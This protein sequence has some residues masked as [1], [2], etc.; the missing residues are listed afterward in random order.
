MFELQ[1]AR[2]LLHCYILDMEGILG[3]FGIAVLVMEGVELFHSSSTNTLVAAGVACIVYIFYKFCDFSKKDPP[4]EETD[5]PKRNTESKH[6]WPFSLHMDDYIKEYQPD[7]YDYYCDEYGIV[8]TPKK[9]KDDLEAKESL[10]A[11]KYAKPTTNTVSAELQRNSHVYH[12]D[13]DIKQ[14]IV[15]TPGK[16]L[17]LFVVCYNNF[18]IELTLIVNTTF[19]ISKIDLEKYP[20]LKAAYKR[21]GCPKEKELCACSVASKSDS[22]GNKPYI[23]ADLAM[24]IKTNVDIDDAV[25]EVINGLNTFFNSKPCYFY[26]H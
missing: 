22:K 26:Q 25:N 9:K 10:D 2:N 8:S 18:D 1:L 4:D 13:H 19:D 7:K 6:V 24:S 14:H 15:V 21:A 17:Y 11:A 12:P 16:H 5:S 23:P 20:K 3:I